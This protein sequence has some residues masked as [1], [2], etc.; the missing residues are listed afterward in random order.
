M[1]TSQILWLLPVIHGSFMLIQDRWPES[2]PRGVERWWSGSGSRQCLRQQAPPGRNFLAGS[3]GW[4]N[5]NT[6]NHGFSHMFSIV[7]LPVLELSHH[8]ILW[9][10]DLKPKHWSNNG[11]EVL[12]QQRPI[13]LNSFHGKENDFR[14]RV[15]RP[16]HSSTYIFFRV[17]LI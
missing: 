15:F 10:E 14:A 7:F 6:G 16:C 5:L 9:F 12:V 13:W 11:W 4:E 2:S 1:V 8:P 3:L 17:G